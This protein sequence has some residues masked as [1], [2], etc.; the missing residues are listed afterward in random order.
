MENYFRKAVF[1][2][3][4]VMAFSAI[5]LVASYG[6]RL[7][8]ARN[9]S[10]ADFG[11]FYAVFAFVTFPHL[12]RELG[13]RWSLVKFIPEN[14]VK[15]DEG[16][17]NSLISNTLSVWLLGALAIFGAILLS[18]KFLA[19]SYFHSANA[20]LVLIIL[21][22][23][24]IFACIDYLWSYVFQG[25]QR[26]G[27]FASVDLMRNVFLISG[28]LI[29]FLLF[30]KSVIVPAAT[31]LAA[32]LLLIIIYTP[33]VKLF[34]F[35]KLSPRFSLDRQVI[36]RSISFGIPITFTALAY[37]LFQQI[38]VL[39]L[40]YFGTLTDVAFLGVAVITSALLINISTSISSV[41][42]PLSSELH[43]RGHTG[44]IEQ[45]ISLIY[46]YTLMLML[47][48]A[49][50]LISYSG[51][52]LA[53]LFG[54]DYSGA[55]PALVI[56][57]IG[58]IFW[59][60]ANINFNILAGMGHSRE[61]FRIMLAITAITVIVNFALIPAIGLVGA[62]ASMAIGYFLAFALSVFSLRS[63]VQIKLPVAAWAKSPKINR[64]SRSWESL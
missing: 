44:H 59:V 5:S 46:K 31:Y 39:T 64:C 34:V 57:S 19:S 21:G 14:I 3:G 25:F 12:F 61:P 40:T 56:L 50:V 23:Y 60:I 51:L 22:V 36:A 7:V 15:K 18:A 49:L 43:T 28:A 45:G 6:F 27:L 54:K 58:T 17:L 48:L 33:V 32:S 20:Y 37:T 1:G 4:Y 10:P 13:F 11:L 47:P 8:L 63:R 16:G 55:A 29:G 41:V 53:T 2:V 38:S 26:M 35:R 52:I 62:A 30:P 42:Y 9:L 24:Y